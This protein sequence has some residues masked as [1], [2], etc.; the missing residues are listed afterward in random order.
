M[1]KIF[2]SMIIGL[3]V[4][5]MV[6]CSSNTH[7]NTNTYNTTNQN[8][9]SQVNQNSTKESIEATEEVEEIDLST[10]PKEEA[11]EYYMN[12]EFEVKSLNIN[13]N[14]VEIELNSNILTYETYTKHRL[15]EMYYIIDFMNTYDVDVQIVFYAKGEDAYGNDI[16]IAT[17]GAYFSSSTIDKYNFES[18]A[19]DYNMYIQFP[20]T[21]DQFEV[22]DQL[23]DYMPK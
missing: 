16:D 5:S 6:G 11:I 18:A 12:D 15:L 20:Q 23:K 2:S 21:A 19:A 9:T 14:C 17:M 7:N 3:I 22:N 13:E 10:L 1:K 8:T 4:L